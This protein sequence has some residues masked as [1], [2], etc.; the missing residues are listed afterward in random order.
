MSFKSFFGLSPPSPPPM[1][2]IAG[3]WYNQTFDNKSALQGFSTIIFLYC[4]YCTRLIISTLSPSSK[5]EKPTHYS[6]WN[7]NAA[8]TTCPSQPP[9]FTLYKLWELS[10]SGVTGAATSLHQTVGRAFY[11]LW[12]AGQDFNV[13]KSKHSLTSFLF[14]CHLNIFL[15]KSLN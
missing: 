14:L 8:P 15:S 7:H 3:V 12:L 13:H 10:W 1:G 6:S 5:M 4:W 2:W 9:M 11:A